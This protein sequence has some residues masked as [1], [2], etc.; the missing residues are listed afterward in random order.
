M[1]TVSVTLDDLPPLSPER[2]AELRTLAE[3][4]DS[5]ID[6]NDIPAQDPEDWADA[7]RGRFFV[8]FNGCF[9]VALSLMMACQMVICRRGIPDS[10]KLCP[11]E[12]LWIVALRMV[13]H[14]D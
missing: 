2:I 4:P 12:G 11:V 5:E 9:N 10:G 8:L 13:A 6:Y 1:K 7:E 3:R 14:E